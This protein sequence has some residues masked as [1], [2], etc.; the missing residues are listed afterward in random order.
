[1]VRNQK[2]EKGRGGGEAAF[3]ARGE[4]EVCT[5]RF[6]RAVSMPISFG[7][8]PSSLLRYT[9]LWSTAT[10]EKERG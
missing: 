4:S 7:I 6:F 9:P 10:S 5:H 8:D 2:V 3:V 1:M